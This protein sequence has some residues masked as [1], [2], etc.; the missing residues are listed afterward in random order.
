MYPFEKLN[1]DIQ[2]DFSE[3]PPCDD[4]AQIG[5]D[6]EIFI[7]SIGPDLCRFSSVLGPGPRG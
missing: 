1:R 2:I 5:Q 3:P 4:V 6:M 7:S